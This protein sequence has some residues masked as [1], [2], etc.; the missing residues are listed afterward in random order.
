MGRSGRAK[1]AGRPKAAQGARAREG[2]RERAGGPGSPRVVPGG[3][4]L[5]VTRFTVRS[6]HAA[7]ARGRGRDAVHARG[8]DRG[9]LDPVLAEL[10]PTW[11][12][13]GCHAGR[14]EVDDDTGRNGWRTTAASGGANHGDTGE[15][16]HTGWLHETRGDEPTARIRRRELDGGESRRRQ[17]AAGEGGN[18]D[19]VT[20]GQ[21]PVVRASTR[22]RESVA[23]VGLGG[24]TP[25]EAGDERVLRSSGGDGGE[26]TAS[27]G[28][29]RELALGAR[30]Q[31]AT[32]QRE[33]DAG[34]RKK[35]KRRER[36]GARPFLLWEKEEGSGGVAAEG[37][38]LCLRPLAA[39]ARSGG[40]RAMTSAMTAGWFGAARRH[41]RQARAGAAEAD[42]GGDQAVGHHGTRAREATGDAVVRAARLGH[43]RWL[44]GPSGC[45]AAGAAGQ[46]GRAATTRLS[47]TR[48]Q[49]EGGALGAALAHARA[50]RGQS[51]RGRGRERERPGG[52]RRWAERDSAHRTRGRQNR[53]LRRN[54]IW[55]D[56]DSEL[57]STIDRGFEILRWHGR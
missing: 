47:R 55:K 36:K 51:G 25:S 57:I 11:R 35:G 44:A 41:G 50:A 4:R 16:E 21:F 33:D 45:A 22:L 2:R 30:V 42:G 38:G 6:E 8:A 13:R 24:A 52:R 46:R 1:W 9:R 39:C 31:T 54:L 29:G 34:G 56:L 28:N 26:Y 14:R 18:G 49:S 15:S 53:L 40:G 20:R 7:H 10:A 17:P 19:E 32:G 5:S 48:G 27:D 12:L 37:G 3:T 23:S 43:A